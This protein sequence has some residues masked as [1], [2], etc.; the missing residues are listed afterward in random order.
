MTQPA[1]QGVS[2]PFKQY[3]DFTFVHTHIA[4]NYVCTG[5][6]VQHHCLKLYPCCAWIQ[7]HNK[8]T[9]P[10]YVAIYIALM[11]VPCRPVATQ[12][13]SKRE[14]LLRFYFQL[15]RCGLHMCH[16]NSCM[17]HI[18]SYVTTAQTLHTG[19]PCLCGVQ[20]GVIQ[21]CVRGALSE[22]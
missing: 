6:C 16:I 22:H 3:S 20:L 17:C 4:H 21:T 15:K 14:I 9:Q 11:G 7:G 13:Q 10:D 8:I 5:V 12:P 1:L 18:N 19:L 2:Q